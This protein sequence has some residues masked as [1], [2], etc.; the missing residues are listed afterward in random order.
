[1]TIRLHLR[2]TVDILDVDKEIRAAMAKDGTKDKKPPHIEIIRRG[3][4][5]NMDDNLKKLAENGVK[6]A[7][8]Y[9]VNEV[10]CNG[11]DVGKDGMSCNGLRP[12]FL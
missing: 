10:L 5:P 3:Y 9:F 6:E 2:Q 11:V 1:M 8:F 4:S 12:H 7:D